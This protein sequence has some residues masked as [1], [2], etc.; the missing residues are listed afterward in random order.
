MSVKELTPLFLQFSYLVLP[1]FQ[2][3][4]VIAFS[5]FAASHHSFNVLPSFWK[6]YQKVRS[7]IRHCSPA[8]IDLFQKKMFLILYDFQNNPFFFFFFPCQ[9]HYSALQG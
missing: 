8:K 1:V 4:S 2:F 5:F 7:E 9:L 6:R 3:C